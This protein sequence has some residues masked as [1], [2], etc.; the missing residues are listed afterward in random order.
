MN[1]FQ[2]P[3]SI[4][5]FCGEQLCILCEGGRKTLE[6]VCVC[7]QLSSLEGSRKPGFRFLEG[8]KSPQQFYRVW[9]A[10]VVTTNPGCL[11]LQWD[12]GELPNILM[13]Y[14]SYVGCA[15]SALLCL[16][17]AVM[18]VYLRYIRRVLSTQRIQLEPDRLGLLTRNHNPS[19]RRE[20]EGRSKSHDNEG[21][22]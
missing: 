12:K 3:L 9:E 4:N 8:G 21:V 14:P 10:T 6:K 18:L 7:L 1:V 15:L 22:L 20:Q 2:A 17:S 19:S 16:I 5:R 11:L 13:D